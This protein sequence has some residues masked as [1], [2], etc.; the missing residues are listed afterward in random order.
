MGGCS[1]KAGLRPDSHPADFA[2]HA[3]HRGVAAPLEAT[4]SGAFLGRMMLEPSGLYMLA[5]LS[6]MILRVIGGQ[7][8]WHA[9]RLAPFRFLSA[10]SWRSGRPAA[11]SL[12]WLARALALSLAGIAALAGFLFV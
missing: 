4:N 10:A 1:V 8:S 6:H 9:A 5:A 2:V 11:S 7:E 12:V 3:P